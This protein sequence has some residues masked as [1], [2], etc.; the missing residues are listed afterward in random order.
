MR[1]LSSFLLLL[2]FGNDRQPM[3]LT[4]LA[5]LVARI[6]S[7]QCYQCNTCDPTVDDRTVG[8]ITVNEDDW[9]YVS[10]DGADDEQTND[11][12]LF[13]KVRSWASSFVVHLDERV[14]PCNRGIT[15]VWD[16]C[17]MRDHDYS[18]QTSSSCF[19]SFLSRC[20]VRKPLISNVV[21]R[22]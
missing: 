17:A 19:P 21:H 16:I 3:D 18:T 8:R 2:L 14:L 9:C 6:S 1:R 22:A 11:E 10:D 7:K 15:A 20:Y 5:F 12:I 4:L 13:R